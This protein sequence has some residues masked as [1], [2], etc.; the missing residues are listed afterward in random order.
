MKTQ[1]TIPA[2][3][4]VLAAFVGASVSAAPPVQAPPPPVPVQ[5]PAPPGP[6]ALPAPAQAPI[7]APA[8]AKTAQAVP[9]TRVFSYQPAAMP[10]YT[11]PA[12]RYQPFTSRSY[13]EV[14]GRAGS[15]F[16]AAGHK[17]LAR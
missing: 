6:K 12:V 11:L 17:V 13:T 4:F 16:F 1:S 8:P 14:N 3:T 7:Q 5:A 9:G 15:G 2:M 10:A